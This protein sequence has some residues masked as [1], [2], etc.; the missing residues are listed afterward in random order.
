VRNYILSY[1]IQYHAHGDDGGGG[2]SDFDLTV[3]AGTPTELDEE[4]AFQNA[5]VLD[6]NPGFTFDFTYPNERR[7][8]YWLLDKNTI[9]TL[10][11]NSPVFFYITSQDPPDI[12]PFRAQIGVSPRK[13][14]KPSQDIRRPRH[15]NQSGTISLLTYLRLLLDTWRLGF[16]NGIQT[17][18]P[19]RWLEWLQLLIER[20][21]R[22]TPVQIYQF[23][24]Q[25]DFA[26]KTPR[27]P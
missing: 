21:D 23:L 22:S 1:F 8:I 19:Q 27:L 11:Q 26:A 7:K 5:D 4:I 12:Q 17:G 24:G 16:N 13:T 9:V 25:V 14:W 18:I 20:F 6:S 15:R 2:T 10:L 3:V